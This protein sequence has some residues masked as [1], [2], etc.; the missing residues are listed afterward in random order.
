MLSG[1]LAKPISEP[2]FLV[3]WSLNSEV[4]AQLDC[5][6]GPHSIDRFASHYNA[7]V[8]RFNSKFMSPGC[9][10]VDTFSLDCE[11]RIIGFALLSPW[12]WMW[13]NTRVSA[14]LRLVLL[15][16]LNGHLRSSGLYWSLCLLDLPP[17]L[18][19]CF[20]ASKVWFDYSRA[21]P[22]GVLPK[23]AVCFFCLSEI[24]HA[25]FTRRF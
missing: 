17:L 7:Q 23:Q 20:L 21:G 24:Y 9:S 12:L 16:F 25:C 4:F 10:A 13:L 14:S 15:S 2:I 5:K 3:D 19:R 18:R 11:E 6:W 1:F 22:E 8:P